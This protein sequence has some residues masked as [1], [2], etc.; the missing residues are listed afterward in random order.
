MVRVKR[1]HVLVEKIPTVHKLPRKRYQIKF[2]CIF[3]NKEK[4]KIY[5]FG[6]KRY[7]LA[8][9]TIVH[10]LRFPL[11]RQVWINI[12]VLDL[13]QFVSDNLRLLHTWQEVFTD[14]LAKAGEKKTKVRDLVPSKRLKTFNIPVH[15]YIISGNF[16]IGRGSKETLHHQGGYG[17]PTR[18]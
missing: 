1:Y 13:A 11:F 7:H 17:T 2:Y 9:L 12:F 4:T 15:N 16:H 5:Q 14:S 10:L 3:I 18:H 6:I 8:T